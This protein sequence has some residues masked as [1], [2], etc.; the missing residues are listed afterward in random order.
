VVNAG[1]VCGGAG[2]AGAACGAAAG[3]VCALVATAARAK[4][5]EIRNAIKQ[6]NFEYKIPSLMY[7]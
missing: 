4:A 5:A 6:Y 7:E 3:A 1:A 2:V